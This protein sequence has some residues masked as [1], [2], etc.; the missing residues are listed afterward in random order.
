MTEAAP[1]CV[2]AIPNTGNISAAVLSS[3]M[4][5]SA[6][7]KVALQVGRPCSILTHAFNLSWCE[8]LNASPRP[9]YFALHHADI[10]AEPGWLDKMID[11][12][13]R[14]G[15][16]V[17][18]C[19][20]PIKDMRGLTST[21][22][23]DPLRARHR[24]VTMAE[25]ASLPVSFRAADVPWAPEKAILG[26][27]TGLFVAKL[28]VWAESIC[29]HN[30]ERIKQN[31]AGE[32]IPVIVPEDWN[33]GIDLHLKGLSVWATRAVDLQH[34]GTYGFPTKAVWGTESEDMWNQI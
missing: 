29:F 26:I 17:L 7:R 30:T 31:D 1:D 13:E 24:R 21:T 27:N 3:A 2:L 20:V 34:F 33:F 32:F 16:D 12:L 22:I 11:E 23:V 10:G 5:A 8:T 4:Q 9:K 25:R 15:A 14:V 6:A 18:S 19:V 28:D